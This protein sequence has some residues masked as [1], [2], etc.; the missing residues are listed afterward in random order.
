MATDMKRT[1]YG[2][3]FSFQIAALL[4]I[5][6]YIGNSGVRLWCGDSTVTCLARGNPTKLVIKIFIFNIGNSILS[7]TCAP[8]GRLIFTS[9]SDPA[10]LT[11]RG[12][13]TGY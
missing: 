10:L 4:E 3:R 1:A 5:N 7:A 6:G 12:L 13:K 8:I 11:D 2:S 9:W